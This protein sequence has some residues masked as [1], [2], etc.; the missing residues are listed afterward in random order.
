[1][2]LNALRVPELV[3]VCAHLGIDLGQTKRKPHIIKLI[4]AT[5]ASEEEITEAVEWIRE[6]EAENRKREQEE[7]DSKKRADNEAREER[8]RKRRAEDE[9]IEK[10]TQAWTSVASPAVRPRL[11]RDQCGLVPLKTLSPAAE[12]L[13]RKA[14]GPGLHL[15]PTAA[16]PI[17]TMGPGARQR[18]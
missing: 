14:P 11:S 16:K 17:V 10:W 8:E 12:E 18:R 1:M 13:L 3:H 9:A 6:E 4:Q 15:S 7:R 2:D 5:D